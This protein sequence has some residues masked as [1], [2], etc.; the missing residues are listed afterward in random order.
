MAIQENGAT[1]LNSIYIL[2]ILGGL[3][4]LLFMAIVFVAIK[5]IYLIKASQ[6]D[7]TPSFSQNIENPVS[8]QANLNDAI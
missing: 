8:T 1:D 2:I 7:E 5:L 3:I 4:I 6:S